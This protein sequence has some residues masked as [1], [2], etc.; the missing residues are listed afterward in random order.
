MGTELLQA[1]GGLEMFLLGMVIMTEGLR[2]LTGEALQ[3]LLARFTKSPI[4][5]AVTGAA[6]TAI[7]QSSSATSVAAIGFVNA[8][9]LTMAYRLPNEHYPCSRPV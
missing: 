7:I 5:G 4:S 8:G 1:T 6:T 2:E 9:L 3:R